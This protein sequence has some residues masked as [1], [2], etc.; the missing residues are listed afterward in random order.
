MSKHASRVPRLF[1]SYAREDEAMRLEFGKHLRILERRGI[2][3]IWHDRMIAPGATWAKE[4]DKEL[5]DA[6]IIV[7]LVSADF[8]T[9][10]YCYGKEMERALEQHQADEAR[11]VP[12]IVRAS[13]WELTPLAEL[14]AL[15][16]DAEPIEE[17]TYPSRAWT[18]IALGIRQVAQDLQARLLREV[19]PAPEPLAD[20]PV[21][22]PPARKRQ[23]ETSKA[24]PGG[25][26]RRR[27]AA[28]KRPRQSHRRHRTPTSN[29]NSCISPLDAF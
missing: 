22:R 18:D 28:P 27:N 11:V 4:I 19:P 29:P 15:P 3:E 13:A 16:R 8:L 14:Q 20:P 6:D 17:W 1:I 23:A 5:E 24:E 26:H 10:D 7:C 12:I 2:I 25:E 9:S 21:E